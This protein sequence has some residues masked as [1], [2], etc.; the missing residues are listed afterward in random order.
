MID[1]AEVVENLLPTNLTSTV[2]PGGVP[3]GPACPGCMARAV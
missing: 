2:L 3:A 1:D